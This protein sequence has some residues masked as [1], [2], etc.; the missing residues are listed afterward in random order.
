MRGNCLSKVKF[1]AQGHM[2]GQNTYSNIEGKKKKRKENFRYKI[3]LKDVED[4]ADRV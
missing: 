3:P 1:L 2:A 4:K